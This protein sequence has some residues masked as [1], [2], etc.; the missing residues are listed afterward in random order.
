MRR[1]FARASSL[2]LPALHLFE[3]ERAHRLTLDALKAMPPI[4][5]LPADPRLKVDLLGLAFPNPF[6]IAAGFDKNAEV[7]SALLALGFG[8][9]EIGGVTPRPQSGNPRPRVFRLPDD[10]ALINRL[11]FNNEGLEAVAARLRAMKRRQ[12][13]IG[14]N[15]G[16]NKDSADRAGDYVLLV[17]GLSALVDYFTVNV[18]SPNT[19]GL[20]DLQAEAALDELMAGVM[21]ARD[22]AA[23]R[24]PVL[25]KI[26]PD[27]TEADLDGIVAVI[28][29]RS[30]DGLVLTNTTIARGGLRDKLAAKETGGLS[31]RPLFRR[32]TILLAKARQRLGPDVPLIG[33]GGVDS[34][35]AAWAK[36]KAGANLIQLYT[37]LVYRG[38]PLVDDM[39]ESLLAELSAGGF[40]SLGAAVG[41]ETDKWASEPLA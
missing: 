1:F 20:R 31:G 26:A 18:S 30:V 38:L 9:V 34:G 17:R 11:G 22:E 19:P 3:P 37:A 6:G 15:L 36:I 33:C 10:G 28:K 25:L 13:I 23:H 27:I 8:H 32:A 21:E 39:K 40:A 16:A 24:R 4:C 7:P 35:Q 29:R 12:G 2:A 14:A 5:A 41:S